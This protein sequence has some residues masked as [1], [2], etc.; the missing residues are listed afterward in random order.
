M[1]I[2]LL[3]FGGVGV[4]LGIS[5][6]QLWNGVSA[7]PE[8]GKGTGDSAALVVTLLFRSFE[9][10]GS[11]QLSFWGYKNRKTRPLILKPYSL[12]LSRSI[13]FSWLVAKLL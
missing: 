9:N 7:P 2:V 11:L 6:K 1:L 13:I 12:I 10:D 8:G 4:C 5:M 3:N